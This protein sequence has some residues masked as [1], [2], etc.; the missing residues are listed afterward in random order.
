MI[1]CRE[2]QTIIFLDVELYE[3]NSKHVYCKSTKHKVN[4]MK[5]KKKR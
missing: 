3:L 2:K 4:K 1:V 5:N